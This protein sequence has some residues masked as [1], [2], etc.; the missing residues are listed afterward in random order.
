M[1]EKELKMFDV[2]AQLDLSLIHIFWQVVGVEWTAC[3]IGSG[4][5]YGLVE[6]I[7][8]D[9][10]TVV[11]GDVTEVSC[12]HAVR[13]RSW[14]SLRGVIQC[15]DMTEGVEL[16][17]QVDEFVVVQTDCGV[18]HSGRVL[19]RVDFLAVDVYKRQ[20]GFRFIV[21]L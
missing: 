7:G 14:R 15:S 6:E 16:V 19:Q 21:S 3:E 2:D 18:S 17:C 5:S 12:F 11:V 10:V 4:S 20:R 13:W 1:S 9:K 8:V